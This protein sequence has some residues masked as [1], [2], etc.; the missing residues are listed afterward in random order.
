M[1]LQAGFPLN[2]HGTNFNVS[3]RFAAIAVIRSFL[4]DSRSEG[5]MLVAGP[6]ATA[7]C[8]YRCHSVKT[9]DQSPAVRNKILPSLRR[10]A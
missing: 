6:A 10:A 8:V 5:F 9:S 4:E 1:N 7:L 2:A 3:F